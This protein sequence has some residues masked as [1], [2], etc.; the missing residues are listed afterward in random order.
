MNSA[1]CI[2]QIRTLNNIAGDSI[3]VGDRLRLP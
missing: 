3:S 1:D 2:S